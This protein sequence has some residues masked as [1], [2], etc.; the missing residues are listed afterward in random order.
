[1]S[2]NKEPI[3][4]PEVIPLPTEDAAVASNRPKEP[5]YFLI[6]NQQK[7]QYFQAYGEQ[8]RND[9]VQRIKSIQNKRNS[10]VIVYYSVSILDFNDAK[11]LAELLQSIG[12][13]K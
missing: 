13:Q 8:R 1:M 3:K 7:Q 12:K 9:R 5:P 2:E 11:I 4:K 10:K 6:L